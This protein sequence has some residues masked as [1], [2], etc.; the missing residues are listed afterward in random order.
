[1]VIARPRGYDTHCA[2]TRTGVDWP[3]AERKTGRA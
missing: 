3:R 1:M 2:I